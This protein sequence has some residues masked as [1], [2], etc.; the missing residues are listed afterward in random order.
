[1]LLPLLS[2]VLMCRR[3]QAVDTVDN[4]WEGTVGSR[5]AGTNRDSQDKAQAALNQGEASR[6]EAGI[7]DVVGDVDGGQEVHV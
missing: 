3:L 4:Q 5:E 7:A 6:S 2:P 1:M